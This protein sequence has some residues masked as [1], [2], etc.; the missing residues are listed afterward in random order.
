M[1]SGS[2]RRGFGA[3]TSGLLRLFALLEGVV[4]LRLGERGGRAER[5]AFALR[6]LPFNFRHEQVVPV[7][8]AMH[9]A[10]PQRGG[11]AVA[12]LIEQKQRVV[13]DGLKVPV[14]RAPFLRP[15]HWTLAGIHVEHDTRGARRHPGLREHL[16]VHGHQPDEIFLSGQQVGLEPMQ[17]RCQ[18]RTP[19]PALWRPDETKGRVRCHTHRVVDVFVAREPAVDRLPEEIRQTELGVHALSGVAQ[20]RRDE[21]LQPQAFIP[22]AHQNKTGVGGDARS[23]ERD[24]QKTIERELKRLVL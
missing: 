23:R 6:L 9:V 21:C 19:V 11:Q 4:D 5:H 10:R 18:R 15:M 14:I 16:P 20:V 17:R 8:G 12:V 3:V 1:L 7:L 13:T 22:L 24:L 2:G